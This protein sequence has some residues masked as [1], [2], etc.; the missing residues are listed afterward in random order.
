MAKGTGDS[1]DFDTVNITDKDGNVQEWK[2]VDVRE[3][4]R[5]TFH[6]GPKPHHTLLL[7]VYLQRDCDGGDGSP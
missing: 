5:G 3:G 4:S 6:I 2:V 1:V 7:S